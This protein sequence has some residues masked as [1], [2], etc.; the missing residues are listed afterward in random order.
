MR[1]SAHQSYRGSLQARCVWA[2]PTKSR[3]FQA[4]PRNLPAVPFSLGR[5]LTACQVPTCSS[6]EGPPGHGVT[7]I[8]AFCSPLLH[9]PLLVSSLPSRPGHPVGTAEGLSCESYPHSFS[10][11]LSDPD[12]GFLSSPLR[13]IY[14]N[15]FSNAT[16]SK[17]MILWTSRKSIFL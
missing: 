15:D 11:R 3:A 13:R 12:S 7:S 5:S 17:V 6:W 14:S 9:R 2:L 1:T 4:E 16:P 10:G 8:S